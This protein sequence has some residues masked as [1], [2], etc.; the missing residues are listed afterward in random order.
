M[1]V[2]NLLDRGVVPIVGS[3]EWDPCVA[4]L[5]SVLEQVFPVHGVCFQLLHFSVGFGIAPVGELRFYGCHGSGGVVFG[6]TDF[7]GAQELPVRYVGNL[8]GG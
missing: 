4:S 8:L 5:R 3:R 1:V 2:N 7:P 6:R